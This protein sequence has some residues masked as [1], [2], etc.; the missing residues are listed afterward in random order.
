MFSFSQAKPT[1]ISCK[2]AA[3]SEGLFFEANIRLE[4]SSQSVNFRSRGEASILP[5]IFG[6]IQWN[7]S[8]CEAF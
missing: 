6:L 2:I 4:I 3:V 8:F 1:E 7:L 5:P